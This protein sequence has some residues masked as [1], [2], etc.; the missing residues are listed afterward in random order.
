VGT[1]AHAGQTDVRITA[2]ANTEA[3]A[4]A[5]IAAMEA[6]LRERLGVA[7]YGVGKE[8]VPEVVG[9]LLAEK[10]LKLGVVDTLT[11][12]QLTRELAGAGF[13]H[14]LATNLSLATPLE[15]LSA[16]GLPAEI[17]LNAAH[18]AALT[19]ELAARVAPP[20]GVGLVLF[21]PLS[22]GE[23]DNLTFMAVQGPDNLR[24]NEAGRSY[25]NTD[26]TRRWLVIQGLDWLRRSILGQLRSPVDWN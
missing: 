3:E 26:Y 5:L 14:L 19:A 23:R 22:D 9:R 12:G 20:D 8:T 21:G 2:K 4:D 17:N 16:I 18:G 11:G 24:I 13:D 6:K 10:G 7:I 1:A 15:V 25:A